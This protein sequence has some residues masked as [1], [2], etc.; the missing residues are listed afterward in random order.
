MIAFLGGLVAIAAYAF[1][2]TLEKSRWVRTPC[3]IHSCDVEIDSREPRYSNPYRLRIEYRYD[4]QGARRGLLEHSS[5]AAADVFGLKRRYAPGNAMV[6]FVRPKNP[7]ESVMD[8]DP[9]WQPGLFL[10]GSAAV[11][12]V[13]ARAYCVPEFLGRP[14]PRE[15]RPEWKR[16]R[17]EWVSAIILFCAAVGVTIG[18]FGVALVRA[19]L[20]LHWPAV[21]CEVVSAGVVKVHTQDLPLYKSD[22]LYRY[23]YGGVEYHSNDYSH[24]DFATPW[25]TGKRRMGRDMLAAHDPVCYVNPRRPDEAVLTRAPSPS[26][27]WAAFGIALGAIGLHGMVR[28]RPRL[29]LPRRDGAAIAVAVGTTGDR[30]K[31]SAWLAGAAVIGLLLIVAAS[32]LRDD[33]RERIATT[34]GCLVVVGLAVL[35][36]GVL[37]GATSTATRPGAHQLIQSP[38]RPAGL[39]A[40]GAG[41]APA[42]RP[43]RRL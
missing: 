4:F 6:C 41:A 20:A 35:F 10:L 37:Y 11:F 17:S 9:L 29:W 39:P 31:T 27:C 1:H 14:E 34:V 26:L 40:A 2:D 13:V 28:N 21:P 5:D 19:A 25:Y 24:T 30:W 32:D 18:V 8:Q 15:M 42:A 23:R 33:Y 7:S 12:G 16:R 38:A 3:V 43:P 22:V 36:V